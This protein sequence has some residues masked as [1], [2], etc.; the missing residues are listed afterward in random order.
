M[1]NRAALKL[2]FQT[3]DIPTETQFADLID[4][5]LS[6]SDNTLIADGVKLKVASLDLG[7]IFDFSNSSV[8]ISDDGV[9]FGVAVSP[10]LLRLIMANSGIAIA[11]D[12]SIIVA[13]SS[14]GFYNASPQGQQSTPPQTTETAGAVYT[15]NEQTMLENL[16]AEV[17]ALRLVIENLG[18]TA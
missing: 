13:C 15:S 10:T 14:I 2:F 8:F 6:K 9:N 1:S 16:K 12:D 4:S 5:L 18:L 17:N 7:V 3:G 11:N